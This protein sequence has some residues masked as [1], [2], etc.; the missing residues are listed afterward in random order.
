MSPDFCRRDIFGI[1]ETNGGV[2]LGFLNVT[3]NLRS[4][5]RQID[6][7]GLWVKP[8]AAPPGNFSINQTTASPESPLPLSHC[9]SMD[10][11]VMLH[12]RRDNFF[13]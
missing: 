6:A 7:S 9:P 10:H 12:A 4:S 11:M 13:H 3:P 8:R 5:R 2:F 1:L